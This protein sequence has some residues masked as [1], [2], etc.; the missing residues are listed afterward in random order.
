LFSSFDPADSAHTRKVCVIDIMPIA[1]SSE[2]S[3]IGGRS[4]TFAC[5][6]ILLSKNSGE[7]VGS[8]RHNLENVPERFGEIIYGGEF[9][10]RIFSG[11]VPYATLHPLSHTQQELGERQFCVPA[12]VW[13]LLSQCSRS[14]AMTQSQYKFVYKSFIERLQSMT[15]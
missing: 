3:G 1:T 8:T 6:D 10:D 15:T 13:S 9:F 12:I 14:L 11:L 2:L 7:H 4:G 5:L